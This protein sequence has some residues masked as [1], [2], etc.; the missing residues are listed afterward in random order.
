M[1]R[2]WSGGHIHGNIVKCSSFFDDSD[3][4]ISD[5]S[6]CLNIDSDSFGDSFSGNSHEG[7]DFNI[8]GDS[9]NAYV[10]DSEYLV[11]NK[12]ASIPSDQSKKEFNDM[13]KTWIF[14]LQRNLKQRKQQ[15]QENSLRKFK[16]NTMHR[17]LIIKEARRKGKVGYDA[18]TKAAKY[19]KM[20]RPKTR[21]SVVENNAST[22]ADE[23]ECQR[24]KAGRA[25][26]H[27]KQLKEYIEGLKEKRE[28]EIVE[29][30]YAREKFEETKRNV[31]RAVL[32]KIKAGRSPR[33]DCK[34]THIP[35]RCIRNEDEQTLIPIETAT[36]MGGRERMKQIQQI[37]LEQLAETQRLKKEKETE[38]EKQ[39]ME[40]RE[41]MK[42]I[43]QKYLEQFAE[44]QRLRKEKE[45]ETEKLK[46]RLDKRALI[47]KSKYDE[48][49]PSS[50][51][52]ER[53]KDDTHDPSDC[54]NFPT[55]RMSNDSTRTSCNEGSS[56][57]NMKRHALL[58]SEVAAL[59]ERLTKS[60]QIE[61][62]ST[63]CND[64][65]QWKRQNGVMGHQKVLS[66]TGSYPAVSNTRH[67]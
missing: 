37:H 33:D 34:S 25:R 35:P 48:K 5:T 49:V 23:E 15:S 22:R 3:T 61:G 62:I 10:S 65:D 17:R 60:N 32:S 11:T 1:I 28:M 64:Y 24:R 40:G 42:Q 58:P 39:V 51:L 13:H 6:C 29:I 56:S 55:K 7:D 63:V 54:H 67:C 30:E 19:G 16:R 66:M 4:S 53:K 50:K 41:R 36:A 2:S 31:T 47:L 45:T 43:Q 26:R 46:R 21:P 12:L 57:E 9:S 14:Q 8:T 59:T 44:T 18:S 27:K 20:E 52:W 38:T